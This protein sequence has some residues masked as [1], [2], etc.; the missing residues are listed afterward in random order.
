MVGFI[1]NSLAGQT[2]A[3]E[4]N[5]ALGD[6]DVF[7]AQW[8]LV[9]NKLKEIDKLSNTPIIENLSKFQLSTNTDR[10]TLDL[11]AYLLNKE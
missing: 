6:P 10:T 9:D 7:D 11:L 3:A 5:P 2:E 8:E 1:K 4:W